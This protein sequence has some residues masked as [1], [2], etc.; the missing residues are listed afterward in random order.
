MSSENIFSSKENRN[1]LI[2]LLENILKNDV[3]EKLPEFRTLNKYRNYIVEKLK[4]DFSFLIHQNKIK[5]AQSLFID[6][7]IKWKKE[8]LNLSNYESSESLFF[9]KILVEECENEIISIITEK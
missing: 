4:S 3:S 7:S 2:I 8:I 6:S 9:D 1:H 5:E